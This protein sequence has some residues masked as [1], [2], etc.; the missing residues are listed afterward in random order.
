MK[1]AIHGY[2]KMG[3]TIEKVAVES[4]HEVVCILD[5][6]RYPVRPIGEA[7]DCCYPPLRKPGR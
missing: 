2:G 6:D 3:R 7:K 5:I 4:G 1:I